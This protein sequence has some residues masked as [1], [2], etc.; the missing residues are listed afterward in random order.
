MFS[1]EVYKNRR[2]K[3]K[4][5][6]TNGIA[7]FLGNSE[8]SMNYPAN[9]YHFRQDSNFL[10][11]FGLDFPDFAGTID[12]ETGQEII[13]A[14][15]LSIDDIVWMGDQPTVSD[16]ALL[17]GI[18]NTRAFSKIYE[19][20]NDAIKKGKKIHFTPPYRAENKLL[21]ESLT[22]IKATVIKDHAS[23]PLIRAIINLRSVKEPCE[24]EELEKASVAGYEM[25]V[26]AMRMA[27]VGRWEQTI[28]GTI[29]GISL[30]YGGITSFPIILSQNGQILHNHSHN[31]IL[32]AGRLM[33][34]DC[35]AESLL[36]Y[37]SD[38]TRTTPVG[39][40]FTNRQKEIYEIVLA[41]NN[42][43][44]NNTKPGTTY[45]Q[46]H[47]L[48]C[49]IIA[50]GL[51]DLGLMKGNVDDAV[52]EGAHALFMPHGLGHMIGLDVHDMEDLGQSLVGYDAE[53][54]PI[55]QFGTEALRF[56]RKLEPGFCLTNEPGIYF[57]PALIDMWKN[58]KKHTNFINYD[59]VE[60]YKDFGGIRLEDMLLVT[61]NGCKLIGKRPPITVEEVESI[62]ATE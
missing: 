20:I 31:N 21:L 27:K 37:A 33:V 43:A 38:H 26:K 55:K 14:D 32:K 62:A 12:F 49:K 54:Q 30:A 13:F 51:S 48:A 15:D 56:G 5:Q 28:A 11:F 16:R 6:M 35:G 50:Q 8:S 18:E 42:N 2:S 60:K 4:K 39:G 58:D 59:I 17:A 44:M 10:Y 41:A 61:E 46:V 57:I 40:K 45:Q 9:T 19:Y 34:C 25:Q 29:E 52:R 23:I 53:T 3:L 7:L 47:L 22:G 36:H 1:A 24:I